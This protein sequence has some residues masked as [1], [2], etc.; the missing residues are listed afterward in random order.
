M[1]SDSYRDYV[2]Q[3]VETNRG[4][5]PYYVAHTCT[6]WGVGSSGNLAAFKVYFS[7]D[8]IRAEDEYTYILS[9]NSIV[10]YVIGSNANS[11]YHNQRVTTG[12]YSGRLSIDDFEFIFSNAEY[13]TVCAQPDLLATSE[14]K[15]SHFDGFALIILVVLLGA[16]FVRL[17]KR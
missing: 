14:V 11:N 5:Y 17:I 16:V 12:F 15:Q 3:L 10:Y 1:W 4:E 9:D 13:T 2:K 7:K 8:P 6:Y